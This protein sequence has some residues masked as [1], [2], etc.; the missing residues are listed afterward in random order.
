MIEFGAVAR[1]ASNYEGYRGPVLSGYSVRAG[2]LLRSKDSEGKSGRHDINSQLSILRVSAATAVDRVSQSMR[3][4][5][6]LD[7]TV[8]SAKELSAS[9]V[10]MVCGTLS[11]SHH[12]RSGTPVPMMVNRGQKEYNFKNLDE[13]LIKVR[14]ELDRRGI[15]SKMF[16][17][18]LLLDLQAEAHR[19]Q[20]APS[21]REPLSKEVRT[22]ER[23]GVC[24][25]AEESYTYCREAPSLLGI[26]WRLHE[27]GLLPM[28][29]L[30]EAEEALPPPNLRTPED[31]LGNFSD[32]LVDEMKRLTLPPPW[33]GS[34]QVTRAHTHPF[35]E[36]VPLA[37]GSGGA[38]V[39]QSSNDRKL[40]TNIAK[41]LFD[42]GYGYCHVTGAPLALGRDGR[43][44]PWGSRN[45]S[46]TE[47]AGGAGLSREGMGE[48][49]Q[50]V[51]ASIAARGVLDRLCCGG[52]LFSASCNG[53]S[54]VSD[55]D[56]SSMVARTVCLAL[57]EAVDPIRHSS[58]GEDHPQ[59][60]ALACSNDNGVN[61]TTKGIPP[62]SASNAGRVSIDEN[63]PSSSSLYSSSAA[64]STPAASTVET[65]Q[66]AVQVVVPVSGGDGGSLQGAPGNTASAKAGGATEVAGGGGDK[67]AAKQG[68]V[69]GNSGVWVCPSGRRSLGGEELPDRAMQAFLARQLRILFES[70]GGGASGT[71]ADGGGG[72]WSLSTSHDSF[73]GE[74]CVLCCCFTVME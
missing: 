12:Q 1:R 14:G 40:F 29:R 31:L 43:S 19:F 23:G 57:L 15:S 35:A 30:L 38:R 49:G 41:Y 18:Q 34:R 20:G 39:G 62:S 51:L 24:P 37:D 61:M 50:E 52:D 74:V 22:K 33:D 9:V 4:E 59:D 2:D 58:M 27:S 11:S 63:T 8:L 48:G 72:G 6:S 56:Q 70:R 54:T 13:Y 44:H 3:L 69:G 5:D 55:G 46:A 26:V 64:N 28:S 45:I 65:N 68:V 67:R 21:T 10:A 71:M 60:D 17:A 73:R 7:Q 66:D 25:G 53:S 47:S 36:S 16:Q 32:T 42:L